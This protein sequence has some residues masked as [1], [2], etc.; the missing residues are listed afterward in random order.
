MRLVIGRLKKDI[1]IHFYH[2]CNLPDLLQHNTKKR[3]ANSLD[4]Y[5]LYAQTAHI[6]LFNHKSVGLNSAGF[7]PPSDTGNAGLG[8]RAA[9]DLGFR[10]VSQLIHT[11]VEWSSPLPTYQGPRD[12]F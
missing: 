7:Y 11:A 12:S 1:F 6:T 2:E 3:T 9:V 5:L 10:L 8:G 4:E